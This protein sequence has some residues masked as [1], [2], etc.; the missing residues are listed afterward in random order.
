LQY[1]EFHLLM[2]WFQGGLDLSR[3][4]LTKYLLI[5]PLLHLQ[6]KEKGIP[7]FGNPDLEREVRARRKFKVGPWV[8][9][10]IEIAPW[11]V[12]D[13]VTGQ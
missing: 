11:M 7:V 13:L 1:R 6:A 10:S 4:H 8:L 9:P 5:G 3:W 2:L 12:A